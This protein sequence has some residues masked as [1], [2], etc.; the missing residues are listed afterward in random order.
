MPVATA[1]GAAP[2]VVV[3]PAARPLPPG[4]T[5]VGRVLRRVIK[6]ERERELEGR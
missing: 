5:P 3:A 4:I 2:V 1:P 6:R